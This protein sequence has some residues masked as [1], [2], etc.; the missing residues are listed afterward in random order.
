MKDIQI[1]F[2]KLVIAWY[3]NQTKSVQKMKVKPTS[4]TTVDAKIFKY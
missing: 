2:M 1:Y 4:F 3:Q